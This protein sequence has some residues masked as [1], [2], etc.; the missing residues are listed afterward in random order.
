MISGLACSFIRKHVGSY[1][2][3]QVV[4][5]YEFV[6]GF[7][8]SLVDLVHIAD[9]FAVSLVEENYILADAKHRVHVMGVYNRCDIILMCDIAEEFIDEY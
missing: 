7:V 5:K 9:P 4:G 2:L 1:F 3:K 8:G 6:E